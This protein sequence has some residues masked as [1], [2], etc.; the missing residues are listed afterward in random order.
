MSNYTKTSPDSNAFYNRAVA[1][2]FLTLLDEGAE[3]FTFQTFDDNKQRKDP[4]PALVRV[5][6]APLDDCWAALCKLSARGAGIFV[7]VNETNGKGRKTENITRIRAVFQ[8]CDRPGTPEPPLD[9]HVVVE[10]SPGKFH[11]YFLVDGGQAFDLFRQVEERL[12]ADYGSDPNAKDLARVLRLPGFPHQK[13]PAKPWLVRV[14]HESGALPYAWREITAKIKPKPFA[15]HTAEIPSGKG[16]DHP[17]KLRSA[18]D[19]LNPDREYLEWL[20]IGM[21]LHHATAGGQQGFKLWDEW[22]AR[23]DSYRPGDCAYK[24]V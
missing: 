4:D 12:V 16:I 13:N 7:T 24:G 3:A 2:R 6:H 11:R 17:A 19:Y 20:E 18:L 15:Q 21:A 14:I 23:G 9:P 5:I 1:L 8:E 22:S 10:S